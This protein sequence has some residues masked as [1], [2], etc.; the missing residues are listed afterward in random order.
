MA[1]VE[2]GNSL[3]AAASVLDGAGTVFL[4]I[5]ALVA[6]EIVPSQ[7]TAGTQGSRAPVL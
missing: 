3:P 4:P 1:V 2:R 5:E 7:E 6:E